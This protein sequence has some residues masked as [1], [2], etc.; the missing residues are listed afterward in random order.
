MKSYSSEK[1]RHLIFRAQEGE[2]LP[3]DLERALLDEA[4][5]C[6]SLRG[7]GILADVEL[8]AFDG[9]NG[10]PAE[11]WSFAGPLQALTLDGSIGLDGGS[12]AVTLRAVL[13]RETDRGQ[14]VMAG[15][16]VGARVV[17]LEV[18]VTALD[19]QA[20][21][22]TRDPRAHVRL[23]GEATGGAPIPK[24]P[25]TGAAVAAAPP[26][27][28]PPEPSP[29]AVWTEA[30]NAS[31]QADAARAA[32]NRG[33][34][35]GAIPQRIARPQATEEEVFIPEEGDI[36]EHFAFGRMEVVKSDGDRLHLRMGKEGRV[37]EIA[38][39]VLKVAPLP[40]AEGGQR[41]FRLDRRV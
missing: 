41:R 32:G 33:A 28:P 17:A 31:T 20:L 36:V 7:T 10:A 6:G 39:E 2:S 22:L 29:P 1:T 24:A 18:F 5:A 15:E 11:A 14:E 9:V 3:R 25:G 27:P 12:P 30:I 26:A 34:L 23:V 37:R 13:A 4:V 35:G 38:L 21:T 19:D 40:P 16:L 8:R